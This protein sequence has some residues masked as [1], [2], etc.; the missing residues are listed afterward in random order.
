MAEYLTSCEDEAKPDTVRNMQNIIR[1][2]D[3]SQWLK[4]A[5]KFHIVRTER[6]LLEF[7]DKV[8]GAFQHMLMPPD[9]GPRDVSKIK[10]PPGDLNLNPLAR[11]IP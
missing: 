4:T 10:P 8:Q 1:R 7:C 6:E 5:S 3:Y 11:R 9:F 2:V